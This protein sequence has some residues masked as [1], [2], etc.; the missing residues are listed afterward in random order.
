MEAAT[1][2]GRPKTQ[3]RELAD[4]ALF[5]GSARTQINTAYIAQCVPILEE[6]SDY[7]AFFVT[8]AGKYK[9]QGILEQIGRFLVEGLPQE[10]ARKL[11]E[12][13]I[14]DYK[15]GRSVKEIEKTLRFMRATQKSK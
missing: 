5:E 14:D 12:I 4:L 8:E 2:K 15:S 3:I 1:K 7:M 11:I 6:N 9:R 13:C 10:E